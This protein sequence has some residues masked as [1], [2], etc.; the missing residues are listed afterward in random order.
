MSFRI[1]GIERAD[2]R[3]VLDRLDPIHDEAAI[4]TRLAGMLPRAEY[5]GFGEVSSRDSADRRR[6]LGRRLAAQ[7]DLDAAARELERSAA[8][9]P[10]AGVYQDLE[11]VHRRRN[12]LGSESR[13]R[14]ARLRL[15]PEPALAERETY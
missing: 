3:N 13:A 7:G 12:D 10:R 11:L 5:R 2:E 4:G 15:A 6:T 14:A 8:L 1:G 9:W